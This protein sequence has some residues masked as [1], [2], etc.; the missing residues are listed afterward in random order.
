MYDAISF[1]DNIMESC[2]TTFSTEISVDYFEDFKWYTIPENL[3]YNIGYM[4]MDLV[5]YYFYTPATVP[6]KDWAF[7]IF[8]LSGDFIFRFFY[9]GT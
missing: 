2:Y 1:S 8:Y 3:V 6:Y 9:S 4:W 5:N 7:F